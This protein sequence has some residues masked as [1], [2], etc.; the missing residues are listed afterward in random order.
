MRWRLVLLF[1]AAIVACKGTVSHI[2]L[3]ERW[4]PSRDCLDPSSAVDVVEGS[5]P[6]GSCAPLCIVAPATSTGDRTIYTSTM[7]PPFPP[8][9][10]TTSTFPGCDRALAAL[11][12]KD[13]CLSDGGSTSP[14]D[15]GRDAP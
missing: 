8:S 10:D 4:D 11:A 2:Y 7:C 14:T 12:R 3:G 6:T 13:V 1:L 9:F 5:A 15:S